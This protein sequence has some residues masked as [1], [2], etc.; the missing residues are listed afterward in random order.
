M[1]RK[2]FLF[3]FWDDKDKIY[4]LLF[5]IKNEIF[6]PAFFLPFFPLFSKPEYYL[7][8]PFNQLFALK[9][10]QMYETFF[11]IQIIVQVFFDIFFAIV[12]LNRYMVVFKIFEKHIKKALQI[13]EGL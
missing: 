6:F 4:Y 13:P 12:P 5:Q 9:R 7:I 3:C 11:I 2:V 1:P 8:L 10:V